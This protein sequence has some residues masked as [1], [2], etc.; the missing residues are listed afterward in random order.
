MHVFPYT[1]LQRLCQIISLEYHHALNK[2]WEYSIGAQSYKKIQNNWEVNNYIIVLNKL[3][4]KISGTL[5]H[6]M[7]I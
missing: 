2:K 6:I 4:Y 7:K 3:H 1:P 5:K